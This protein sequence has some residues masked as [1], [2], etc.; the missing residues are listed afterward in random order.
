MFLNLIFCLSVHFITRT[1]IRRARA[2]GISY[3]FF[4]L[5]Y[6]YGHALKRV[7]VIHVGIF[8]TARAPA[9]TDEQTL[10]R[11]V[12]FAL[13]VEEVVVILIFAA[14]AAAGTFRLPAVRVPAVTRATRRRDHDDPVP[15]VLAVLS[16]LEVAVGADD[17][18][19]VVLAL[20][21][22][23]GYVATAPVGGAHL[24]HAHLVLALE[25]SGLGHAADVG[26]VERAASAGKVV[27]IFMPTFV[28]CIV[29]DIERPSLG[30]AYSV[31]PLRSQAR[32]F[33]VTLA[34]L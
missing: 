24:V 25:D 11:G 26:Q 6:V 4:V 16:R 1:R 9:L 30:C 3:F 19:G 13:R 12:L 32:N 28:T 10:A 27:G 8:T 18:V 23:E 29:I 22:A 33:L 21:A 15:V 14:V 34:R 17:A 2:G 7:P 31:A 20:E 5:P